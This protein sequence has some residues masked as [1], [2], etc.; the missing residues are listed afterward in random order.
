MFE[1]MVVSRTFVPERDRRHERKR[2]T[3]RPRS[4]WSLTLNLILKRKSVSRC[5]SFVWRA[6]LV[7]CW[8]QGNNS[9]SMKEPDI[10]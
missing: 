4:R 10:S 3:G 8:K 1:S 9:V 2:P 7:F 6:V 5:T